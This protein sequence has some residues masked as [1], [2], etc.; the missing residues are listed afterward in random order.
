MFNLFGKNGSIGLDIG[1]SSIRMLQLSRK[2]DKLSVY[3]AAEKFFPYDIMDNHDKRADF[4]R[5]IIPQMLKQG[6]FVGENVVSA[7]PNSKLS[8][9][10][11]RI[12][13][14]EENNLDR[15]VKREA[16]I[17]FSIDPLVSDINYLPS[18]IVGQDQQKKREV[19]VFSVDK[20]VINK[21]LRFL[22][23]LSLYSV[24][25]DVLPC[26]LFR[27]VVPK[28]RRSSDADLT[29]A[30]VDVGNRYTTITIASGR[31]IAFVKI[32]PL[33]G[34]Q[35]N[36]M[37]ASRLGITAGEAGLLRKKM[38]ESELDLV[39]QISTKQAVVD[40]MSVVVSEIAREISLCFR[41]YAVTF[42]G[43][44]PKTL[45]LSG[46]EAYEPVLLSSLHNYLDIEIERSTPFMGIDG[47]NVEIPNNR[48]TDFSEWSVA[49][50]L[51]LKGMNVAWAQEK[52][53]A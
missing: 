47:G 37:I 2:A 20:S 6:R 38:A 31:E 52:R 14:G 44:R 42:R 25:F 13:L 15:D 53:Y 29:I 33:G 11:L 18:G 9:K 21:R 17:R 30:M 50:G 36:E 49:L 46:G 23:S 45:V 4:L 8:V 12:D 26:A 22:E 10:S 19:V 1:N 34:K 35:F 28:L 16:A 5:E 48:G 3:A 40:S 32:I 43:Q 41:Y 7:V 24:G 39:T 27:S 51:S